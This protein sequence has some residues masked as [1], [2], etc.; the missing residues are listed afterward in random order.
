MEEESWKSN[1]GGIREA[2]GR[3]LEASGGHLAGIWEASSETR[4]APGG[5]LGA[6][7]LQEGPGSKKYH[8]SK[9]KCKFSSATLIL[10][11]VFEGRCLQVL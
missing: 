1:H 8:T 9:L 5:R 4:E 7:G 6:G 3:H 11:S 2:S 10:Q